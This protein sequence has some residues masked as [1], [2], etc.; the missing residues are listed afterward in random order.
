MNYL[1]DLLHTPLNLN[2]AGW[3]K[4]RITPSMSEEKASSI[5]MR[6]WW[7]SA[8]CM[9]NP[10]VSIS[11]PGQT[12]ALWVTGTDPQPQPKSGVQLEN[13]PV[14][15][16]GHPIV[17]PYTATRWL[18]CQP[19]AC[20]WSAA[21]MGRAGGHSDHSRNSAMTTEGWWASPLQD[22]QHQ[23]LAHTGLEGEQTI[24]QSLSNTS[25][26]PEKQSK[27]KN[28]ELQSERSRLG[29]MSEMLQNSP[30][31]PAAHQNFILRF[32]L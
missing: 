16:A 4:P 28:E 22:Q 17:L 23:C 18:Y 9:F 30:P 29:R 2:P 10:W 25:Q 21:H 6:A 20:E 12:A 14:V 8:W 5:T 32:S 19:S 11:P 24:A 31:A 7:K 27:T 15:W 3:V 13:R 1:A 26:K